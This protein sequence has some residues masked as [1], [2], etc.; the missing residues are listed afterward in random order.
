MINFS[1]AR[2][3]EFAAHDAHA[4]HE[5]AASAV[6]AHIK[7]HFKWTVNRTL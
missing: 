6:T 2:F 1:F 4:A 5:F 7:Y 3:N